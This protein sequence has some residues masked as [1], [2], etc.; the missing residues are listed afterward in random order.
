LNP[1][2][3]Y[4]HKN[5]LNER[6]GRKPPHKDLEKSLM[7]MKCFKK[8]FPIIDD[9]NLVKD[10]Y[11]RFA[12][13]SEELNDFD[14]IYDRWV[15]DPVKWWSNHGQSIPLLQKIALKLLNQP[16]PSSCCE[17]NWSTSL[18]ER[19]EDLVFVHSNLRLLSRNAED[20]KSGSSAMWDV[21]GDAFESLSG[22]GILEVTDL[23]ID[24]PEMKSMALA[25]AGDDE[26]AVLDMDTD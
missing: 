24:E 17:R 11:P 12:T 13:S 21:G 3:R 7:R 16:A 6:V 15:L 5:W 4:Y 2:C 23:S 1:Y 14:A 20:Y 22:V 25:D 26:I 9:L 19:A 8:F 18:G 10:E